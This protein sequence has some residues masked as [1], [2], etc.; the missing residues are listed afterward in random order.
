MKKLITGDIVKV[1]AGILRG[2][3]ALVVE[4]HAGNLAQVIIRLRNKASFSSLLP[5]DSLEKINIT[6]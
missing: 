1:K 6:R 5:L 3:S 2:Y 4:L